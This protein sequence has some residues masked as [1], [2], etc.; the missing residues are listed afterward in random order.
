MASDCRQRKSTDKEGLVLRPCNKPPDTGLHPNGQNVK[1]NAIHW[2][3]R[4]HANF[5]GKP[6]F[7]SYETA[8]EQ[9]LN[10]E[11]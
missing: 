8:L 7:S 2:D 3:K 4:Q 6:L 5:R 1:K 9:Q 11:K 10:A